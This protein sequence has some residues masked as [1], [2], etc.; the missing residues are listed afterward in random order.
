MRARRLQFFVQVAVLGHH[1]SGLVGGGVSAAPIIAP[2]LASGRSVD[3]YHSH[4]D[5]HL[6][7][8][9]S[10]IQIALE[11]SVHTGRFKQLF[12][13]LGR[14][15]EQDGAYALESRSSFDLYSHHGEPR[16]LSPPLRRPMTR[17]QSVSKHMKRKEINHMW[18]HKDNEKLSPEEKRKE[19][20]EKEKKKAQE[21][22]RE[23]EEGEARSKHKEAKISPEQEESLIDLTRKLAGNFTEADELAISALPTHQQK[24]AA[25]QMI[26]DRTEAAIG[27]L[28]A[29]EKNTILLEIPDQKEEEIFIQYFP[30][31][32]TRSSNVTDKLSP[33]AL[34]LRD[35]LREWIDESGGM[36]VP[37]KGKHG[38]HKRWALAMK[39][40]SRL[41]AQIVKLFSKLSRILRIGRIARAASRIRLKFAGLRQTVRSGRWKA[42]FRGKEDKAVVRAVQRNGRATRAEAEAVENGATEGMTSI[43]RE[44]YEAG[45]RSVADGA[46]GE[47][48]LHQTVNEA[49]RIDQ[50]AMRAEFRA[51]ERAA[52]AGGEAGRS[53]RAAT[54]EHN[55]H[56]WQ[57]GV[58][59][60]RELDAKDLKWHQIVRGKVGKVGGKFG[61]A[62]FYAD[63]IIDVGMMVGMTVGSQ[64]NKNEGAAASGGNAG[65]GAQ[66]S[67][68][69]GGGRD[70]QPVGEDFKPPKGEKK[71]CL[72]CD[73]KPDGGAIP[74]VPEPPFGTDRNC[75]DCDEK[76]GEGGKEKKKD[77]KKKEKK[78]KD[79]K[80]KKD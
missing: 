14:I 2:D 78:K 21:R 27:N 58:R 5:G 67:A 52:S 32:D 40:G 80:E 57:S 68:T 76:P 49:G 8:P 13:L 64:G 75:L 10:L 20:E 42:L 53:S 24:D 54:A 23:Q 35:F 43:Q 55:A 62:L 6:G 33:G 46:R 18:D 12:P 71:A 63:P 41:I 7:S 36:M 50:A 9:S 60:T 11:Q 29:A 65:N 44:A 56:V 26:D 19:K 73:K 34:A 47:E 1:L 31:F 22:A 38:V 70:K 69:A 4:L 74:M 77:K 66:G 3:G 30:A 51:S 17:K 45:G 39:S 25:Q 37:H 72:D 59:P 79:K 48:G 16:A 28:T 61:K 15:P